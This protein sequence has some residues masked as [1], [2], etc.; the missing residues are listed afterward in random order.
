MF[1]PTRFLQLK[2]CLLSIIETR[3]LKEVQKQPIILSAAEAELFGLCNPVTPSLLPKLDDADK[4]KKQQNQ[5][6]YDERVV[7]HLESQQILMLEPG[8]DDLNVVKQ[9]ATTMS[10]E[11][12]FYLASVLLSASLYPT[13]PGPVEVWSFQ[14]AWEQCAARHLLPRIAITELDVENKRDALSSSAGIAKTKSCLVVICEAEY[15]AR[16]ITTITVLTILLRPSLVGDR[17]VVV[18]IDD[19]MDNLFAYF[20]RHKPLK[21]WIVDGGGDDDEKKQSQVTKLIELWKYKMQKDVDSVTR[22]CDENGLR[23]ITDDDNDG[24]G[25]RDGDERPGILIKC[26]SLSGDHDE[27]TVGDLPFRHV[28]ARSDV[29]D[30]G[31]WRLKNLQDWLSKTEMKHSGN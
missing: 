2:K 26:T 27:I 10:R 30:A 20:Q 8:F 4:K 19:S 5:S 29:A 1:T 12:D 11:L 13:A 17:R 22:I 25:D 28:V 23:V 31:I 7:R 3:I 9:L 6:T 16:D 24:D 15:T 14:K 18:C 21:D